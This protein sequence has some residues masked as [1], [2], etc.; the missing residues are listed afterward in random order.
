MAVSHRVR[1]YL[2]PPQAGGHGES[3]AGAEVE[4]GLGAEPSPIAIS[5]Q[6]RHPEVNLRALCQ[7]EQGTGACAG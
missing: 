2:S 7:R 5:R 3:E 1:G 4:L 6:P